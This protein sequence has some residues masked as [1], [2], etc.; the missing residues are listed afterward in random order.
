MGLLAAPAA[1]LS[2]RGTIGFRV[3]IGVN[4]GG[5]LLINRFAFSLVLSALLYKV[6]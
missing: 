3:N 6:H 4:I 1:F 2:T 5:R